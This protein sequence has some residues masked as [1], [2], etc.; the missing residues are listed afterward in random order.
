MMDIKKFK[1]NLIAFDSESETINATDMIKA[2]PNKRMNDFT[3]LKQTQ[4]FIKAYELKTGF[5]VIKTSAGKYGGTYMS[6]LLAYK[7]AAWLSPEF[8]LFVYE[9][10]DNVIQEKLNNQQRQ[11]DYF[12]NKS[13]IEDLYK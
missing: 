5:P 9:T 3:S 10:F 2:F 1:N 13:D 6:K 12:W 11:L 8:E 4:E 7:F